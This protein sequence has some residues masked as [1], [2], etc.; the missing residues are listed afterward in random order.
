MKHPPFTSGRLRHL[1]ATLALV[2]SLA[3]QPATSTPA[4]SAATTAA[5]SNR[6]AASAPPATGKAGASTK[7]PKIVSRNDPSI[8]TAP[9]LNLPRLQ[10]RAKPGDLIRMA[11]NKVT[12]DKLAPQGSPGSKA[13][14][15]GGLTYLSI[16]G[17]KDY[18]SS[19]R[20]QANDPAFVSFLVY[21]SDGTTLDI[22]GARLAIKATTKP[23]YAQLFVSDS[24]TPGSPLRALPE[25]VRI[26]TH[27]KAPLAAL[28]VLT[29]RLDP[30]AKVWDLYSF[31][32]LV[33][34]DLPLRAATA[35]R[36]RAAAKQFALTAGTQ[37]ASIHS[38]VSAEENPLF[39]DL[40]HNGIDDTFERT[41]RTS[42]LDQDNTAADRTKLA[43]EWQ[44]HQSATKVKPW[45]IRRPQPDGLVAA[46]PPKK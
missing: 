29:V 45:T 16:N 42:L 32:R 10:T 37:G 2:S 15:K 22:G 4:P 19:I 41:K 3:A 27:D 13:V 12:V 33:A 28:P 44:V 43:H 18:N 8:I 11:S 20:G 14:T 40:N 35:N 24:A 25:F 17:G 21:A 23:G 26:E 7:P 31:N 1:A 38:L 6:D 30:K 5:P 39:L 46:A 9:A 36:G 34:A